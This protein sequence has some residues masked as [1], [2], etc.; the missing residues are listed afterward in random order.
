MGKRK[1]T[2]W[3]GG[4]VIREPETDVSISTGDVIQLLPAVLRTANLG[5]DTSVVIEAIYLHF[6]IHRILITPLDALGFLVWISNV[7]ETSEL[8]VQSLDAISVD[9]RAYA[10]KNILMMEPLPVPPV[11]NSGD[12]LSAAVNDEVI[13]SSHQFRASRKLDRASNVLA[14][15]LNSDVSSVTRVFCQWRILLREA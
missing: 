8:P 13:V 5:P 3:V 6:H 11:L 2:F 4:G 10:N 12:L 1:S 9:D 14:M 15:N 7:T